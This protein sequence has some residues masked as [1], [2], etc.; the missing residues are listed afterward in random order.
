MYLG[1][2]VKYPF[3]LS[4][5]NETWNTLDRFSKNTQMSDFMKMHPVRVELF[6]KDK[7]TYRQ[8][9]MTGYSRSPKINLCVLCGSLNKQRLLIVAYNREILCL[10][11]GTNLTFAYN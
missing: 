5:A 6:H 8:T 1:L 11:R 10:L 2:H 7:R 4:D 9:D 3:F